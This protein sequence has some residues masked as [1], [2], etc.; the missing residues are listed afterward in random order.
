MSKNV[1]SKGQALHTRAVSAQP[2]TV[3]YQVIYEQNKKFQ[4]LKERNGVW[5]IKYLILDISDTLRTHSSALE[6]C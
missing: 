5:L 6:V 2:E 4:K 3:N 1:I